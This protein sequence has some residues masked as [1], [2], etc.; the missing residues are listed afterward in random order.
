M[1][2]LDL[3]RTFT[4]V[5]HRGSFA[6]A[7]RALDLS[8]AN[9]SKYV[10]A[11]EAQ[12]GVR[13][14]NRSTR[15]VSLTDAGELLLERSEPLLEM[16]R[17]T[18]EALQERARAPSGRLRVATP[19]G[20][21]RTLLPEVL[22]SFLKRHPQVHVDLVV[23]NAPA[24]LIAEGI[25]LALRVGRIGDDNLIVRRL[26]RVPFVVAASPAFWQRN[27]LPQRHEQLAGL[28]ALTLSPQQAGSVW[29]FELAEG[30]V[31]V[32]V[33]SR[34]HASDAEPLIHM[35]RAGLGMVW[36]PRVLLQAHLDEGTLVAA[37]DGEGSPGDIWLYAA[38]AQ[39]RHNS[40]ALKAFLAAIESR[41]RDPHAL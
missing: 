41:W 26:Q 18:R 13:L 27:G 28:D 17:A 16:V 35:A 10:A 29:H 19:H 7:A 25:D 11:L 32:N 1:D 31:E 30:P 5:A 8:K 4:E 40:A 33:H 14:F 6:G 38:Y 39:R 3:L 36:L 2:S 15:S 9:V 22:A 20:L 23:S 21:A 37:L 12:L 34:M 24:D